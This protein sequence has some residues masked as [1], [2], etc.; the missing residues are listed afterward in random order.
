MIRKIIKKVTI[1][2]NSGAT[3]SFWTDV[4][5]ARDII[6]FAKGEDMTTMSRLSVHCHIYKFRRYTKEARVVVCGP[7][8]AA[9]TVGKREKYGF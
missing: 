2:Y 5:K 1:R 7:E 8:I 6:K 9:V 3:F 4:A